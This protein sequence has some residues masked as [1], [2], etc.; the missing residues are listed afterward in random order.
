M[1]TVCSK[2]DMRQNK[3]SNSLASLPCVVRK[4]AKMN[5]DLAPFEYHG[6]V[7]ITGPKDVTTLNELRELVRD[8]LDEVALVYDPIELREKAALDATRAERRVKEQHA[9]ELDDLA[10]TELSRYHT[11]Q[12]AV[13]RKFHETIRKTIESNQQEVLTRTAQDLVSEGNTAAA[14]EILKNPPI[15]PVPMPKLSTAD[16]TTIPDYKL[17]NIDLVKESFLKPRELDKSR[18]RAVVREH[19]EQA[20]EIVGGI[21]YVE[22]VAPRR[23]SRA[24]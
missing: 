11:E 8:Y 21:Q 5:N 7:R 20:E 23:K 10:K 6:P 1:E 4:G 13:Q 18:V 15:A 3:T 2:W 12:R 16:S 19:K 24:K 22:R 9:R 17:V 14:V